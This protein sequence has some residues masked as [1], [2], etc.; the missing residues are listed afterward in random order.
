MK[1]KDLKN[2]IAAGEGVNIEFKE[3]RNKLNKD[4]FETVCAFLNRIGGHIFLG[5]ADDG[6]II[7]VDEDSI[8][9]IKKDL[10]T[11][12]NNPMKMNPTFYLSVEEIDIEGVKVLYIYIPESSQVHRCN[13]KIYDRNEDGD[14]EITNNSDLVAGL[15]LRKQSSYT[16]NRIFPFARLEDLESELLARVRIMAENQKRSH[17]WTTMDDLELL[18]SAGL[19]LRDVNKDVEG[20]TLAGILIFGTEQ[21]I[22]SALP[23]HKTDAILRKVNLDRYDDRDDIRVNLIHSY[24]RL[25]DFIRKHLNDNF[26]LEGDQRVSVRDK[27]FREAIGNILIH[28]EYANPFPAKMIIEQDRVYMENGNRARG[29][30]MIDLDDFSPFPKNPNIARFFKEI[31][32]ADELGSGI[33][34]MRK[35]N[36]IYSGAE[37]E[38]IE[39]DVFKTIIPLNSDYDK[40]EV[41]QVD[42]EIRKLLEFCKTPKTMAEIQSFVGFKHRSHYRKTV[43]DPL[44]KGGLLNLV[45]P[46]KPTSPKQKYY[47]VNN[48][49]V[50][51]N[52]F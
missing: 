48:F 31:G 33:R 32:W 30:G 3:C 34:N 7:G 8:E 50:I 19:Y 27:I 40:V 9:Q 11:S 37:P 49:L 44:I 43:I 41:N 26:Y 6:K 16:E 2:L 39:G 13:G 35:Y 12:M 15:Y 38:L 18:K 17:P 5:V 21:L 51:R 29:M 24:E 28:R 42:E 25:L 36:L 46:D 52:S 45:I 22:R 23:H 10:V 47:S 14:F 4:L 1:T 20:I